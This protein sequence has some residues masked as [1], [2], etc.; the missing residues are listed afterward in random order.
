MN[1]PIKTLLILGCGYVGSKLI[2]GVL[3]GYEQIGHLHIQDN[4]NTG[5]HQ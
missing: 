1:K 5:L 2:N 3:E 4:P